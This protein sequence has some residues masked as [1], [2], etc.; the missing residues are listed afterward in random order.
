MISWVEIIG[1]LKKIQEEIK[2]K[3]YRKRKVYH[4]R[5]QFELKKISEKDNL[6][7]GKYYSNRF[8]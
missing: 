7:P 4:W 6:T 5:K 1:I 8:T 2:L 3:I